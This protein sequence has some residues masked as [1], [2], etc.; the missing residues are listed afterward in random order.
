LFYYREKPTNDE[1]YSNF[2]NAFSIGKIASVLIVHDRPS[3]F[4]V[5]TDLA[6]FQAQ[7]RSDAEMHLWIWYTTPHEQTIMSTFI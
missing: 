3:T 7:A 1:E 6:S 5:T 2:V 4:E